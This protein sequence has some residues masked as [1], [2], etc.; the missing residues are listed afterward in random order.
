MDS[1]STLVQQ[2]QRS[3]VI[4]RK[5]I[6]I[7]YSKGPVV[8]FGILFPV[9]LFLAFAVG[10]DFSIQFM[11][12][13]LLGMVLFFTSTAI[14]PAVAPWETQARTLER[15]ISSPLTASTIILGDILASF[16]FGFLISL[17]P[18]GA[19]LALSLQIHT[20]AALFGGLILAGFCFSSLGL[21]FSA[22]PA[23]MP[24][25]IMMLSSMIKFPV[26]FISGI[27]IPLKQLPGW[28]KI[29]S[30]ISP[31]TY[32]TDIA[33]HCIQNEGYLSLG[34]DFLA[35]FAFTG[36]FLI[37]ALKLHQKTMPERI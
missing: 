20:P 34:V 7:Y 24:S 25:T 2:A 14:S 29:I 21:M 8:I 35:L 27:F 6:R 9:F 18:L 36:L 32:F 33:R 17:I 13:G 16:A 12:P 5:N 37:L 11:L 26:V 31:L 3:L 15:L 10:R 22:A 1:F 19:G 4:A 23:T 30:Y 28:G